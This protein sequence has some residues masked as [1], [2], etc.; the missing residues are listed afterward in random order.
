M[1][2]SPSEQ[3]T[4]RRVRRRFSAQQRT[5][6]VAAWKQSGQSAREYGRLHGLEP[7]QLY[8]WQGR[9]KRGPCGGQSAAASSPR[10]LSLSLTP[11]EAGAGGAT[12]TLR[13]AGME[14]VVAGADGPDAAAAYLRAIL[15]EVPGV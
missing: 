4:P 14:F 11:P 15:R 13:R 1:D 3:S 2:E 5:G 8:A 10:F 12:V 7:W 6:H 9:G